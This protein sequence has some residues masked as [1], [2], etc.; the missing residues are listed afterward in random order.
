MNDDQPTDPPRWPL[1]I[2]LLA[3]LAWLALAA[4]MVADGL[5]PGTVAAGTSVT[6]AAG[7]ALAGAAPLALLWLIAVTMR[8]RFGARAQTVARLSASLD[9]SDQRIAA[10]HAALAGIDSSVAALAGKIDDAATALAGQSQLF[11]SVTEGWARSAQRLTVA[12]DAASAAGA[13]LAVVV[14]EALTRGEQ[15]AELLAQAAGDVRGQLTGTDTML[16]TIRAQLQAAGEE[17]GERAAQASATI[18]AVT[19][20]SGRATEALR[21][22]AQLLADAVNS[23]FTRTTAAMD[24]SRD[25]V[26]AQTGA[27]L[28]SVEQARVTLD[29]IGGEAARQI[30]RRLDTLSQAAH[31]LDAQLAAQQER[32]RDMVDTAERGFGILDAKLG[33]SVATGTAALAGMT[34]RIDAA[35]E[36]VHGLTDPIAHSHAALMAVE[37]KVGEVGAATTTAMAALTGTLPAALPLVDD[38]TARLETL[39]DRVAALAAPVAAGHEAI[40]AADARLVEAR[41]TLETAAGTLARELETARAALAEIETLTGTASLTASTELIDVFARVREIAELTAGTMRTTLRAVVA[42]AETALDT[43]GSS[44]AETAFAAPVR[45]QLAAIEAATSHAVSV[46]QTAA[47]RVTG[48][49]LALTETVATVE[50]RIAETDARHDVRQR[51]DIANRSATLIESLKSASVDIARLLALDVPDADWRRYLKGDRSLFTRRTVRLIDGG[52]ARLIARHF[53]HDAAFRTHA[54]RYID[55]FD[56]L[57]R[58]VEAGRDGETLALTLLSS[59]IGKLYVALA[60]GTERLR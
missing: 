7:F 39:H 33:N 16:T 9:A 30:A 24:A 35:R 13:A 51:D 17:A 41:G 20:A 45:S 52:S 43:A 48:R 57:I 15:L 21:A 26:H 44:R 38:L 32:T 46:A 29:Q 49:L 18:D 31:D 11:D 8:D 27:L 23:A 6:R 28:A 19:A 36:A 25:G 40:A 4:V 37:T 55:E 14:P 42:E 3:T 1:V 50:A 47:E 53:E 12:G 10:A 34:L 2:A 58:R 60:Q 5:A 54:T 22:P 56:R 59:D